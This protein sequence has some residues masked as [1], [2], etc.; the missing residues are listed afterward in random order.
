MNVDKLSDTTAQ[1]EGVTSDISYLCIH[2]A[3]M[4]FEGMRRDVHMSLRSLLLRANGE[5]RVLPTQR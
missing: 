5:R 1:L 4:C 3:Y 2:D